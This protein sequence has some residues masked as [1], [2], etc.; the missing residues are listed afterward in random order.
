[1]SA[2]T[3]ILADVQAEVQRRARANPIKPV[4]VDRARKRSLVEAIERA[5]KAPLIAEIKRA[6]PSAG[7]IRPSADVLEVAR[8]MLR[9]G[10]I[11]LSVLTEP[12]YFKGDPS[13]LREVRK[14]AEVPLLCKDFIVDEYQLYE[15]TE[16]GA[17]VVLL[18]TKALGRELPRFMGLAEKL[19]MESLV[20]VTSEDE[21]GLAVSAGAELMGV[22]NR[23]LETLEV[24]LDRT[25][26]LAPLVPDDVT[27]V[28][29]SGI[30]SPADVR[31]MLDAGA[32]AVL[33]GTALMKAKN[34]E[35]KVRSLVNAR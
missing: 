20:E 19:G 18:I 22:N 8:A 14:V 21:I 29:E 30:T 12:K 3:N 34:I 6:S 28:S 2:L 27:L 15:A 9:G 35:Q 4:Y 5:P 25:V 10:A 11:S 1:M 24:D 32:D 17:D 33:V 13:F 16:L 7:D 31:R 23:D 26:R